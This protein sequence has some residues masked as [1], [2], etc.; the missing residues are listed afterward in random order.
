MSTA[1]SSPWLSPLLRLSPHRLKSSQATEFDILQ[2]A[3]INLHWWLAAVLYIRQLAVEEVPGG[4]RE[5]VETVA[6]S[7]GSHEPRREQ[8]PTLD[9]RNHFT[10]IDSGSHLSIPS[11]TQFPDD[12]PL[13]IV[14]LYVIH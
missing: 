3:R 11:P 8:S 4:A 9:L 10:T 1:S 6:I 12:L 5:D 14:P 2:Y 13:S 7:V